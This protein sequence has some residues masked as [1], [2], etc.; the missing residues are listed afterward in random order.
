VPHINAEDVVPRIQEV[1]PSL[2]GRVLVITG[3]V[4]D[5]ASLELIE[6]HC[7]QH[8]PQHRIHRELLGQLRVLLKVS[9]SAKE[10]S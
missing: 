10:T 7:L 2:V 3:E 5:A 4:A 8:V 1:R 9:P 6:R